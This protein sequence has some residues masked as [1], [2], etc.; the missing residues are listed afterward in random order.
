MLNKSELMLNAWRIYR[1]NTKTATR[2]R[3]NGVWQRKVYTFAE[4]LKT[5]WQARKNEVWAETVSKKMAALEAKVAA[6][7]RANATGLNPGDEIYVANYGRQGNNI[8]CEVKGLSFDSE[9]QMHV[10]R[11]IVTGFG[12]L[13]GAEIDFCL[14]PVDTVVIIRKASPE[15]AA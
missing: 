14:A 9:I 7:I 1:S 4:A 6:G 2:I 15:K 8:T 13:A 10:V 11:A 5:A 3:V 12:T